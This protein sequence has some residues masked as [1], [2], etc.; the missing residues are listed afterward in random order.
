MYNKELFSKIE[1]SPFFNAPTGPGA[2]TGKS[3]GSIGFS[4]FA[5]N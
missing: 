3:V 5:D 4:I 1:A 2:P